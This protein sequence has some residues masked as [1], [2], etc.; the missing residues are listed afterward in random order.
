MSQDFVFDKKVTFS[1]KAGW[2]D[3][4]KIGKAR[5]PARAMCLRNLRGKVVHARLL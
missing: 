5:R 3:E 4:L 2:E 1:P